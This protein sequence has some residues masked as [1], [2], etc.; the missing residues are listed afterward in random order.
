MP[1]P[2]PRHQGSA[3]GWRP[4]L[5]I[6][7][8]QRVIGDRSNTEFPITERTDD[9]AFEKGALVDRVE[10]IGDTG[11]E[12]YC[13]P[14]QRQALPPRS[15]ELR[16]G[17]PRCLPSFWTQCFEFNV[18]CRQH[19]SR[20][21]A[22]SLDAKP[23]SKVADPALPRKTFVSQ[24]FHVQNQFGSNL[25]GFIKETA[26]PYAI[27]QATI[28]PPHFDMRDPDSSS[29]KTVGGHKHVATLGW[30]LDNNGTT[31][32]SKPGFVLSRTAEYFDLPVFA[33]GRHRKVYQRQ[34]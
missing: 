7:R 17:D 34:P 32:S 12:T 2:R 4:Q 24:P 33:A 16:V 28:D 25:L 11:C 9:A 10:P 22:E 1:R 23:L 27:G 29:G 3:T 5:Q 20:T 31:L 21:N 26:G 18:A 15:A 14:G 19:F 6:D 30:R 8:L 13:K